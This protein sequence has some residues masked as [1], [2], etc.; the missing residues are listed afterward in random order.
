MQL[1]GPI[2]GLDNTAAKRFAPARPAQKKSGNWRYTLHFSCHASKP[3]IGP[4]N[5]SVQTLLNIMYMRCII[6][7]MS[8]RRRDIVYPTQHG[9]EC[10]K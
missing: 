6:Y 5:R 8:G 1:I 2:T 7:N 3:E 4:S 9:R 10:C